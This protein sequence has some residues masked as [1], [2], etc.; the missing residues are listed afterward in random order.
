MTPPHP[1]WKVSWYGD[2]ISGLLS[3]APPRARSRAN[4]TPVTPVGRWRK[5]DRI[6]VQFVGSDPS[7]ESVLLQKAGSPTD[8]V[9]LTLDMAVRQESHAASWKC[10]RSGDIK[11][12]ALVQGQDPP[13]RLQGEYVL[14]FLRRYA[15]QLCSGAR[16]YLERLF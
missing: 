10:T 8:W 5:G 6:V 2:T 9:V 15:W 16:A 3:V 11:D 4:P 14:W 12:F 7:H 1:G 13:P